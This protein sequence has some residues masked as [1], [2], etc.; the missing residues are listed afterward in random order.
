MSGLP[1]AQDDDA[2]LVPEVMAA[3]YRQQAERWLV[4]PPPARLVG[5]AVVP[6]SPEDWEPGDPVRDIDWRLTLLE[7]GAELGPATPLKR[8]PV[9]ED[10]GFD[11]PLWQPKLEL[12][13]DVSG[14]MPDPRFS[15]NA[16]TLA[17]QILVTGATRAGGRARALLYSHT[18]VPFW[19]WSRSTTEL[20]RFLMHYVGGGTEFPFAT[21][22][23][24]VT[25]CGREQP[26]RVVLTDQDFDH[27]Y[28][29][30]AQNP[31]TFADA[32]RASPRLVL[33][34]HRPDP[35]RSKRYR[36]LGAVVVPIDDLDDF[37]RMAA[38]LSR[39]L[40]PEDPAH[41]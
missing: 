7:H 33:L 8:T 3:W 13:L 9:A 11:V 18:T 36:D 10:E 12:Y 5:E 20:S 17:A 37:P 2:T 21:L 23:E 19:S 29:E 6:T 38:D 35:T 27:N 39:A 4:R 26:I 30:D 28:D 40:F 31:R 1:G 24:S 16:M 15:V 14:S 41:A 32:V 22:A 25:S 34:L